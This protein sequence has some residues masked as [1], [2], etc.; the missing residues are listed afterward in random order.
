MKVRQSTMGDS[1]K[2]L[3]AMQYSIESSVFHGGVA[4][5]I[6]TAYH[7]GLERSYA[8]LIANGVHLDP[9]MAV[10]D[11]FEEFD[12]LVELAPSHESEFSKTAGTFKWDEK[13]PDAASAKVVIESMLLGY[14]NDTEAVWPAEW[15]IL[16]VE[17]SFS[18]PLFG[19]HT[20]NGSIDLVGVD[21]DGWVFG[22]DHKTAGKAW[23]YNKHHARKSNQAPWYVRALQELY[24]DAPGYR[25]FYSIM[26]Y[27]GK[28]DRREVRVEAG[29]IEA[30]DAKALQVVTIYEG[31]RSAGMELPANPASNLC[32]PKYCD[33]FD[34]CPYGAALDNQ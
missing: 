4:R 12:R 34:V 13:F 32:S 1:D 33:Y 18:L 31:M 19:S 8:N 21:P 22:D 29:H 17:Q 27:G 10:I 3:R 6:G 24:P 16:A 9:R 5:A 20:R 2:C 26:T 28:F 14:L 25:F 11:A 15:K 7:K 23:P 30:I